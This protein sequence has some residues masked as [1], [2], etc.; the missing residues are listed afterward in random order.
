VDNFFSS[1]RQNI[2]HLLDNPKMELMR[3]DVTFPLYVEVDEI[4]N[5]ACPASPIHYQVDP[6][7]TTKTSVIGAINMLGLA[8]R[9]KATI[10]QTSASKIYG[11]P[12]ASSDRRILG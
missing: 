7:Q 2:T 10:L 4:F 9:V 1:T 12:T 3:H 8:K 6:V 5:L 11:D